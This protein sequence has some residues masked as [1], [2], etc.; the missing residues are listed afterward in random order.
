MSVRV[1]LALFR[2]RCVVCD[3]YDC[4]HPRVNAALETSDADWK[5]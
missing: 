3:F 4:A 1:W 5:L 2:W